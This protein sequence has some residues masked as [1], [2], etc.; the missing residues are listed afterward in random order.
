VGHS[1]ACIAQFNF[2]KKQPINLCILKYLYYSK[3]GLK[4]I[5]ET[6]LP[7]GKIS[8]VLMFHPIKKQGSLH[9]LASS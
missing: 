8:H 1:K 4:E 9:V 7:R 5:K 6:I 2:G 3:D